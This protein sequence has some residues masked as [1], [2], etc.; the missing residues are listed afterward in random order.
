MQESIQGL[1]ATTRTPVVAERALRVEVTVTAPIAAVWEAWSTTEGI[2]SFL[3]PRA[4]VEQTISGPY[5]VFFNPADER[6]STKGC[7]LLSYV[8]ERMIAFQW[9]LPLDLYPQF[10]HEPTWVVVELHPAGV[11]RTRVTIT[12]WGWGTGPVWDEAYRHMQLGWETAARQLEQRFERGPIDWSSILMM[13]QDA[14]RQSQ[15]G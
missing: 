2:Q 15:A 3:A 11:G 13:W 5:E 9:R 10:A 6:M 8:P 4:R 14:R 1:S 7:K 12:Q